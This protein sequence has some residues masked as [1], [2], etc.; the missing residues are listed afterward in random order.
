MS[1]SQHEKY[2]SLLRGNQDVLLADIRR[3]DE[4]LRIEDKHL[5]NVFMGIYGLLQKVIDDDDR[6]GKKVHACAEEIA[7]VFEISKDNAL[8][9][10]LT[11]RHPSVYVA[12]YRPRI[13]R[14]G[15][16]VVIRIGP[17]TTQADIKA[18]WKSIRGVQQE[19]GS[20]G[21]K[22]SINPEL[23]FCIHRQYVLKGRK[24]KDIFDDYTKGV[25]EGYSHAPTITYEDDFRKYYKR[26]V[27]GI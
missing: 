19:I 13:S 12:K 5:S 23:G 3:S 6:S 14:D 24:M 9:L 15:D 27:K 10:L 8:R 2:K 25:L 4:F 16:E 20:V 18:A 21:S 11:A 26:I 7:E 1:D 22:V 17:K